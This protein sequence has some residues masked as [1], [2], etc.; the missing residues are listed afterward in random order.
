M[1]E[2]YVVLDRLLNPQIPTGREEHL[3]GIIQDFAERND[4]VHLVIVLDPGE[5][6]ACVITDHGSSR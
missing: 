2:V 1:T 5:L 3:K 6:T 4:W